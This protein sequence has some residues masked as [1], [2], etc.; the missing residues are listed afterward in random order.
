MSKTP[1]SL[2]LLARLRLLPFILV[3]VVSVP[4]VGMAWSEVGKFIGVRPVPVSVV[5]TGSMY[6]S[7]FWAASEG[8][9]EDETQQGISE[10]RT[11]PHLFRRFPGFTL[12]G[13]NYLKKS[14]N[15]GDMVAFK[16]SVT[17]KILAEENKDTNSGFIKR[18]I[19]VPGDTLELRDG[20]VYK[21][22]V[23]LD[24]PYLLAPRSTYGGTSL[25]DCVKLTIPAGSYFVMGDNR[26]LSSDSR[27]D[28]GLVD[29]V[30]ITYFLPLQDQSLYRSLWRD[31]SGDTR[32]LGQPTLETNQF[33]VLL[34]QA[35]K[36][37]G[38]TPLSL[39]PKLIQSSALRANDNNLTL[40]QAMQKAGYSNIVLGEFIAHGAYTA[41]ELLENLLYQPGTAKQVL[42]PDYTDLGLSAVQLNIA[43]CPRQVIVGHLGGYLPASY[44]SQTI[45]SWQGLRD[46]LREVLPSWEA[47]TSYP[48]V[49]QEQLAKLLVILQRRL[50]LANEITTTIQRREWFTK[51]QEA[52]IKA[53]NVDALAAENLIEELNRE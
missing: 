13:Q 37:R 34:N 15:Y 43:G 33:L 46:N 2:H 22:G 12:F 25:V 6:P 39:K 24:E 35:R 23:V 40:R 11:T 27:F 36:N 41:T 49:N 8:G 30:N 3:V 28:L 26:K 31:T 45:A 52:R 10:Y 14:L 38:L 7:L 18:I 20:F 50:D 53:D 1:L 21:D 51:D 16:N 19:G 32:L 17:A 48:R 9:P 42:N 5:G 47:A 29:E 44:D 4:I